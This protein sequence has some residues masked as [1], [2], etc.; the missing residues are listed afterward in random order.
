MNATR[1]TFL[2]SMGAATAAALAHPVLEVEGR[3]RYRA[4]LILETPGDGGAFAR[5]QQLGGIHHRWKPLREDALG[6]RHV[7]VR[8]VRY[9]KD[10]AL[11]HSDRPFHFVADDAALRAA[12]WQARASHLLTRDKAL[13]AQ[14]E[15]QFIYR[16]QTVGGFGGKSDQLNQYNVFVG[17]PGY[18]ERDLERYRA[19]TPGSIRDACRLYLVDAPR[20]A[21]SFL[22]AAPLSE[23]P[24]RGADSGSAMKALRSVA[25][26]KILAA[27]GM[28]PLDRSLTAG[29]G[30]VLGAMAHLVGWVMPR[31]GAQKLTDALVAH[32]ATL[33]LT[34]GFQHPPF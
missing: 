32:L 2:C 33:G 26:Q 22:L 12:A 7:A 31:G 3:D 23:E 27:H 8:E 13:L 19:A 16:V 17:D 24:E 34:R 1:R 6:R 5:Q 9:G 15:A 20:V 25:T 21:V 18:F 30:L 10:P 29:F 28:L 14:A 4:P 11:M